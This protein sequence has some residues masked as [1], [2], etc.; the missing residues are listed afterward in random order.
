MV[1]SHSTLQLAVHIGAGKAV[2]FR[3]SGICQFLSGGWGMLD[4][5]TEV[6]I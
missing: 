5:N 3:V 6:P 4:N 2:A 1:N